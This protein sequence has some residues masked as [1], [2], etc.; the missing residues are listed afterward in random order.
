MSGK[1]NPSSEGAGS[2]EKIIAEVASP[3]P[4]E[5]S[6]P[7]A[8]P[9]IEQVQDAQME[10]AREVEVVMEESEE[11]LHQLLESS[12]TMEI[13]GGAV[14]DQATERPLSRRQKKRKR[15]EEEKAERKRRAI[16]SEEEREREN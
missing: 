5:A 11:L 2:A 10:E 16:E 1:K 12:T 13:D 7:V 6:T 15:E 8:G 9:G 3:A 14:A 4:T